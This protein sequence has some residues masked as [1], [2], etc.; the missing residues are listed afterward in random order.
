MMRKNSYQLSSQLGRFLLERQWKIAVAE[1]CTG[2]GLACALTS[3][4]GASQWFDRGFV[5]YSH[6]AKIDQLGV[7]WETL[8]QSGE[9]SKETAEEM[10]LG[11]L[12]HSAAHVTL[13]IT[14]IAGP[15]GHV[16]G[17]PVGTVWFGLGV[18]NEVILTKNKLFDG[19][20][21]HVRDCSVIFALVWLLEVL[22]KRSSHE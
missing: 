4:A 18:R 16:P 1:S 19:G 5:T 3:V 15:T 10:A 6:L 13:S 20:R 7:R 17:K 9:V 12:Q 22:N 8:H 21:Q 11:A 14:G 2:G